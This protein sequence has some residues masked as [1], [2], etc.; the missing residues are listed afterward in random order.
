MTESRRRTQR[1]NDLFTDTGNTHLVEDR[2]AA[3]MQARM[4]EMLD[5]GFGSALV[6]PIDTAR[7][8]GTELGCAWHDLMR[9]LRHIIASMARRGELE[10]LQDGVPVDIG[11][12]RGPILLRLKRPN[13]T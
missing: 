6:D 12:V 11:E 1:L 3:C 9:P 10:V 13:L 7:Q 5:G 2:L 4:R 8:V